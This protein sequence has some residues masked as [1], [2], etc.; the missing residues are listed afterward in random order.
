M[1]YTI[2]KAAEIVGVSS[3]TLRYYEKEGLLPYIER[4]ES[5]IRVYKDSDIFWIELIKCLKD[6][7]MSISEIHRI[8]EL[9]LE[10]EHTI[11][12]R[13]EI[14]KEHKKKLEEQ[15]E[16]LRVCSNKIDKKIDWYNGKQDNC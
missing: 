7:G 3:Y 2:S 14:L 15:M 8:V 1:E 4:N 16:Q 5:G 9:S 11:P 12:E 10:G 6:T 13:K